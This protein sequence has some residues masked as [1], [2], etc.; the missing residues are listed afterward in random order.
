MRLL[1][2]GGGPAGLN[3]ALLGRELGAQVILIESDRLGG[4]SI[5][6]GPAPVRTL[7]GAARLVRDTQAWPAFGLRGPAP[8]VD[9]AATLANAGRVADS[10]HTGQRLSEHVAAAER[11]RIPVNDWLQTNLARIFAA[12]DVN[13]RSMLV[14][15]AR[16]DATATC[17][18]RTSWASTRPRS[19]RSRP[20]L[21]PPT[22][23]SSSSPSFSWPS[24]P[25]P[26]PL[27]MAAQQLV[28]E[29]GVARM[30]PSPSE[31]A[32]ASLQGG[33]H[34]EK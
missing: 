24:R 4:T 14:P 9:L 21:W 16:H 5:N 3:A 6:R 10:A 18:A 34:R 25:S 33:N 30:P 1:V 19:S 11:G 7:A 12:G 31:L 32:P 29:L 23:A 2:L 22:C 15:S 8:K 28:R 26:R 27:G 17:W 20:W 13:G